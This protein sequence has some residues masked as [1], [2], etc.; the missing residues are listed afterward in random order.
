[1]SVATALVL[2]T[3]AITPGPNNFV[4]ME[5]AGRGRLNGAATSFAGIVLGTLTLVIAV[6]FGL[7]TLL[8]R[9]PTIENAL[10]FVGF[11]LLSYLGLRVF[12]NGWGDPVTQ[13]QTPP[14]TPY[15]LLPAL[16]LLQLVNPKTWVLSVTVVS[17]HADG[18]LVSLV[19]LVMMIPLVCL[20]LWALAGRA[21]ADI[22]RR[23]LFRK[24][25]SVAMGATLW[26]FAV[27]LLVNGS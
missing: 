8:D 18:S 13:A 16:F 4:V 22:L 2:F 23:P 9:W 5:A 21:L 27:W 17:V 1:M 25:F 7:D 26:M 20:V 24:L 14:S 12:L 11:G 15:G 10:R 3:A 6:R 19:A